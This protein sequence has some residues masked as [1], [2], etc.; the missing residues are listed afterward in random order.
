MGR[1]Y[2]FETEGLFWI[3]LARSERDHERDSE[4]CVISRAN[5]GIAMECSL[6]SQAVLLN[7]LDP[8]THVHAFLM[9][10]AKRWTHSRE[11]QAGD[12][13]QRASWAAEEKLHVR[14][15]S[16]RRKT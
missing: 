16:A 3:T 5:S 9:A 10:D 4:V 11:P 1:A 12:G 15:R 7:D 8:I 6:V 13:E 14:A 2:A